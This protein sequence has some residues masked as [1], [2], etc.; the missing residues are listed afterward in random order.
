MTNIGENRTQELV[1]KYDIIGNKAKYHMI[2][3][4]QTN[5]VKTII[6]KVALVHSLDR[7]S[8]A[9]ELEQKS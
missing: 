7:L 8:L 5:K 3:H 2:G 4:L 6:D 9:K 1:E